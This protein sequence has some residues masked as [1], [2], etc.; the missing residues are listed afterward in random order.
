MNIDPK[1][2]YA[3]RLTS[4]EVEIYREFKSL[5]DAERLWKDI[6]WSRRPGFATIPG[7]FLLECL[8]TRK[9]VAS[10]ENALV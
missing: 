7:F 5:Q 9:L 4:T 10:Q 1:K 2:G 8:E 3:I 6:R